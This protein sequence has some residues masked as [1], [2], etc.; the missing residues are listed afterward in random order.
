[1]VSNACEENNFLY[2]TKYLD[3]LKLFGSDKEGFFFNFNIKNKFNLT[4]KYSGKN[5]I[6]S[7]KLKKRK[8]QKYVS[9]ST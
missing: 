6:L 5:D 4:V 8:V 1:M 9:L 2:L 3:F 7:D